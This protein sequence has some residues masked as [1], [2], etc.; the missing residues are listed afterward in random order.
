[1][2][3]QMRKGADLGDSC[4]AARYRG[5]EHGIQVHGST[6]WRQEAPGISCETVGNSRACQMAPG[7][8]FRL[9]EHPLEGL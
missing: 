9:V 4:G 6:M 8:A 2:V 1:M 5:T 3:S 7:A